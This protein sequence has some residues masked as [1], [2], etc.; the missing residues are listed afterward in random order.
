[1]FGCSSRWAARISTS[2]RDS[3]SGEAGMVLTATVRPE[4]M[5]SAT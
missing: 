4:W 1:M 5:S 2:M 3:S